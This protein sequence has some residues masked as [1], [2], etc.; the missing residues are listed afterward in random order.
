[1]VIPRYLFRNILGAIAACVLLTVFRR[2]AER[3]ALGLR[4]TPDINFN[5]LYKGNKFL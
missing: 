3:V 2:L 5:S 1:M 4:P